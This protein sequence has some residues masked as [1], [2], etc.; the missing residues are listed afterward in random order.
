VPE[1]SASVTNLPTKTPAPVK[2]AGD[3]VLHLKIVAAD[4]GQ[5]VPMVPIDYRGWSGG[6]FEGKH[7]VTDRF[8]EYDVA[9]PTNITELELTTRRDGFADTQLLWRP[10]NGEAIPSN[11]VARV[12]WPV[13]IGGQVVDADGKPVA[14][15]KVGWNNQDDP[16][17]LTSPQSHNFGWIETQTDK[18]GRWR[19]N[20]IA[21]EM[22][23]M[24][25]GSADHTNYV[26]S[27][28]VFAGRDRT[29]EKQ[30][31][32]GTYI[33]KLG[34]ATT[35]TGI[36]VDGDGN[37]V[38]DAKILVGRISQSGGRKGQTQNDG[39]FSISGC[40]PGKQLV[41]AEA[42]GFAAT[43]VKA[44]L[45]ENSSPVRLT[46]GPGKMLRLRVVDTYG[47]PIP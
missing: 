34:R 18:D 25:Y 9:Y 16:G 26:G 30:L 6:K 13:A 21:A 28:L 47:N 11:Y 44:D 41:T 12:D 15:A 39:T 2:K 36:V 3:A 43:T 33:F 8:G 40:P 17:T 24:I 38:L 5:P 31:R 4:S 7:F 27:T 42:P 32:D 1:T 23:P 14:D 20:R 35:V 45:S 37:P 29:V 19:I 10:P 22:I 46:L